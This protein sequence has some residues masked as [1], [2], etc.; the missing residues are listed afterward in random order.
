MIEAVEKTKKVP[1][2][3][4]CNFDRSDPNAVTAMINQATEVYENDRSLK[5]LPPKT[6]KLMTDYA[7][8]LLRGEKIPADQIRAD[9]LDPESVLYQ[10]R[11]GVNRHNFCPYEFREFKH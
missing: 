11:R 4:V 3:L 9:G 1:D 7:F 2:I 5:K 6:T 10:A 8:R